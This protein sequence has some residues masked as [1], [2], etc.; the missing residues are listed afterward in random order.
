MIALGKENVQHRQA[1]NVCIN[2]SDEPALKRHKGDSASGNSANA[3]FLL[4]W[5]LR[6]LGDRAPKAYRSLRSK[7]ATGYTFTAG[8]RFSLSD[9][10]EAI[11]LYEIEKLNLGEGV[12]T[13]VTANLTTSK[14]AIHD[15]N[16]TEAAKGPPYA[17][18]LGAS[19]QGPW[20][21][22]ANCLRFPQL[23]GPLGSCIRARVDGAQ[24][25]LSDNS[26]QLPIY[27]VSS[28]NGNRRGVL[29]L[30]GV[31]YRELWHNP[32]L[33]K[34]GDVVHIIGSAFDALGNVELNDNGL[35]VAHPDVLLNGTTVSA[36]TEC[37]RKALI[38]DEFGDGLV[39]TS[40]AALLG[41]V[42]HDC[43]QCML[44]AQD[45]S[46]L[47]LEAALQHALDGARIQLWGLK[48]NEEQFVADAREHLQRATAWASEHFEPAGGGNTFQ[49]SGQRPLVI[50]SFQ[51]AEQNV[52]SARFG[53]RGKIDACI[54][55][56]SDHGENIAPLEIK[57]GRPY[58]EHV[59]QVAVYRLLLGD[60]YRETQ[61]SNEALLLYTKEGHCD[62]TKIDQRLLQGIMQSRNELA[63]I[64]VRRQD[65]KEAKGMKLVHAGDQL[66][67]PHWPPPLRSSGTCS[68]CFN[69]QACTVA[70]AALENGTAE[71]FG[72]PSAFEEAASLT[73]A[74]RQ[75]ATDWLK[76]MNLEDREGNAQR[77]RQWIGDISPEERCSEQTSHVEGLHLVRPAD[78]SKSIGEDGVPLFEFARDEP[79]PAGCFCIGEH[80]QVS[81]AGGPFAFAAASV[82]ALNRSSIVVRCR[83]EAPAILQ[84]SRGRNA[85]ANQLADIEDLVIA[86]GLQTQSPIPGKGPY[87]LDKDK[88]GGNWRHVRGALVQLVCDPAMSR[89]TQ[90]LI[91]LAAP[92]FANP[93]GLFDRL[94]PPVKKRLDKLNV[95][96]KG[97]V[98]AGLSAEDYAVIAGYPGAG[99]TETIATLVEALCSLGK[100]VLLCAHTHSAVDNVLLRIKDGAVQEGDGVRFVR[101]GKQSSIHPAL[102]PWTLPGAASTMSVQGGSKQPTWKSLSDVEAF[103]QQHHLVACTC[104]GTND[105]YISGQRFDV[106]V[107]DEASQASEC[108]LW[109]PLMLAGGRFILVGDQ[110]QLPPLV[111]NEE[112]QAGCMGTSLL[113]RL[114]EAHPS[115]VTELTDQYRMNEP[116]AA[117]CSTLFYNNKLRCGCTEVSEARLELS[118]SIGS[119]ECPSWVEEVLVPHR[120]VVLVDTDAA[121]IG[122]RESRRG[123]GHSHD[124]Q[125]EVAACQQLVHSLVD[126][127]IPV[128]EILVVSPYRRQLD[129][130]QAAF[131]ADAKVSGVEV[132]TIDRSQGRGAKVVIF[133]AVR[134]NVERKVG[135]L[136]L[137]WRRL[138]VAVSRAKQ[139]LVILASATTLEGHHG[140]QEKECGGIGAKENIRGR[141]ALQ[142]LV[143]I[144]RAQGAEIPGTALIPLQV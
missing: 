111:K 37:R 16:C 99:K 138:N 17:S 57:T 136:L 23:P 112:A 38:K 89:S 13:S 40:R 132:S 31:W 127:G 104:Q 67:P 95:G 71:T 109:R 62:N 78:V 82:V 117:V 14:A 94:P 118:P 119:Q 68:R 133:S 9:V 122:A 45:F 124:N 53:V 135:H 88:Y 97:A 34:E 86:S 121:G 129:A 115:S 140:E 6:R 22:A 91:D 90:V 36:T 12:A 93:A 20:A 85:V 43:I 74:K 101:C 21:P 79:I 134:S 33:L 114:S 75:Y 107:I 47:Q 63:A 60:L 42:V 81:R 102:H 48:E 51:S 46:P 25:W 87:R 103:H 126:R 35:L 96:Q 50:S 41:N 49:L 144:C 120:S 8:R 105:A 26:V 80:I 19:L 7:A 28:A 1:G 64:V 59:G 131:G 15:V 116:I 10:E 3:Q 128:T 27:E 52:S 73:D 58:C 11:Q 83:V 39:A 110:Q 54:W 92:R 56:R 76:A 108:Q 30:K 143:R 32:W 125:V 130:M 24:A 65:K 69:R 137:D 5:V 123:G 44:A 139:K 77:T 2:T 141:S 66:A 100:R 29:T 84:T 106:A 113:E 4:K 18:P 70:H 98:L 61:V 142:S 55:T 72:V